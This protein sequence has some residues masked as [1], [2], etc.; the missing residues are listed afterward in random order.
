ME[1]HSQVVDR[2]RSTF[3]S[4][5]TVPEQFRRAQLNK[6]MSLLNDNEDRIVEALH[7]DLA[8]VCVDARPASLA[9]AVLCIS[10]HSVL[11]KLH[12]CLVQL[13]ER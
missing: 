5:V 9:T 11:F 13:L 1:T 4:G 10:A 2:L 7:K 3:R 6:L 12:I 8:K